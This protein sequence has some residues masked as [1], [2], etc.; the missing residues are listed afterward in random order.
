M[1]AKFIRGEDPN[2]SLRIGKYSKIWGAVEDFIREELK[3]NQKSNP[4]RFTRA[5]DSPEFFISN[6]ENSLGIYFPY[7][8]PEHIDSL[9]RVFNLA[10]TFEMIEQIIGMD[11][12]VG[13]NLNNIDYS[14]FPIS[15]TES[16]KG[17]MMEIYIHGV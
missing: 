16:V 7:S 11:R 6:D 9:F 15:D 4:L 17:K 13:I 1:R 2:K 8:D 12:A 5:F 3:R 10:N 14:Q